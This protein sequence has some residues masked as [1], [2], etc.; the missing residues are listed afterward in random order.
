MKRI[1]KINFEGTEI[2]FEVPSG[3]NVEYIMAKMNPWN[4]VERYGMCFRYGPCHGYD[5][6]VLNGKTWINN[7]AH[8]LRF[9]NENLQKF[10]F[11]L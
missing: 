7:H 2:D 4:L 8:V 3:K 9:S 5:M 11:S 1:M 10:V 6:E